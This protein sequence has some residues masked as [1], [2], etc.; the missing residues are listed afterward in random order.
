MAAA[1]MASLL[2]WPRRLDLGEHR[3]GENEGGMVGS[4]GAMVGS[5]R[6]G[7]VLDPWSSSAFGSAASGALD[8]ADAGVSGRYVRGVAGMHR[9]PVTPLDLG[10]ANRGYFLV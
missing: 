4:I 6:T 7:V 3:D 5:A 2:R 9:W 1:G 8:Y 10:A